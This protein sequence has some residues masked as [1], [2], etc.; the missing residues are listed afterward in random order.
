MLSCV[1]FQILIAI[2]SQIAIYVF[3]ILRDRG[4]EGKG[5]KSG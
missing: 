5:E 4:R 1:R 2:L 3:S